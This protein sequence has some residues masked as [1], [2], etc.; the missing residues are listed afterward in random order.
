MQTALLA[1]CP[2]KVNNCRIRTYS[3]GFY[4]TRS[5]V[6]SR[7]EG[8]QAT[9]GE[10][11][12]NDAG[13]VVNR[14]PDDLREVGNYVTALDYGIKRLNT[15]P[16]SL[17]LIREVH[18]KLMEGVRGD[19]ATP[20]NSAKHKIGSPG[21]LHFAKRDLC[22]PVTGFTN[23]LPRNMGTIYSCSDNSS[24]SQAGLLH[25][26]L[27]PFT[28]SWMVTG[29]LDVLWLSFF[30]IE[31]SAYCSVAVYKRFFWSYAQWVL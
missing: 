19:H 30:L 6:S 14:S 28:H 23:G 25:Y 20:E 31:E 11:L 2:E 15:L 12:A 21:R 5:C 3:Y 13:A 27:K 26:Q 8:T 16:L 1:N 17:R 29:E 9:L 24:F 4:K 7:I 18:E 10:L 22:S